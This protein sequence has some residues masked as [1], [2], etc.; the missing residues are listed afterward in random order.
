[1]F[2][3]RIYQLNEKVDSTSGFD[4]FQSYA[5][6]F[7]VNVLRYF[8]QMINFAMS[9]YVKFNILQ[10]GTTINMK[11]LISSQTL[12]PTNACQS[13]PTLTMLSKYQCRLQYFTTKYAMSSQYI[14]LFENIE[15]V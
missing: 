7:K 6:T 14:I 11:D 12:Q 4:M 5:L 10:N 13:H 8:T 15:I 2:E 1:M 3:I 9:I